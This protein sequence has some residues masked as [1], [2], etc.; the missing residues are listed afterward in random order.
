M[1]L[2]DFGLATA[3]GNEQILSRIH[4]SLSDCRTK[5]APAKLGDSLDAYET[6]DGRDSGQAAHEDAEGI[7][8]TYD[9]M[10]PEQRGDISVHIDER[11][12]IYAFGVL[13]YRMLT[14]RRPVAMG[15]LPSEIVP[16]LW[17][18]WDNIIS[19][20][21]AFSPEKRY[22]S[23]EGLLS[24]LRGGAN[25]LA[26][27]GELVA[28][29]RAVASVHED[30]SPY[31]LDVGLAGQSEL[32]PDA[33]EQARRPDALPPPGKSL[34]R[35]AGPRKALRLGLTLIIASVFLPWVFASTGEPVT[36]LEGATLLAM[37]VMALAVVG[38]FLSAVRRPTNAGTASLLC[39]VL[40]L[41]GALLCAILISIR[42]EYSPN[43]SEGT[44]SGRLHLGRLWAAVGGALSLI[45]AGVTAGAHFVTR[46]R[47][48]KITAKPKRDS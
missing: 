20:C 27:S 4:Q 48:R 41:C 13:I 1:V 7:L 8:G 16:F 45:A 22:S 23:M 12:D 3:V 25:V 26:P 11:T 17:P 14:G 38:I 46:P 33:P 30:R 40:L 35:G 21:L 6:L 5:F 15:G 39:I 31:P 18:G 37:L 29:A 2:T 44:L 34:V 28:L 42:Y 9:Y 36:L 10:A 19:R 32:P 47:Q 24:D 43:P